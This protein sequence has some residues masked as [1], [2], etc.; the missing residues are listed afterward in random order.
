M[1]VQNDSIGG[2]Y[3]TISDCALIS[4]NAGGI[5]VSVSNVR[6]AGSYIRSSGGIP[7]DWCQCS[8]YLI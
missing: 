6:A 3:K 4:K 8:V 2:I 7:M 1:M 5:G